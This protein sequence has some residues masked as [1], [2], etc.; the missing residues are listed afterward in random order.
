MSPEQTD[1]Q[2]LTSDLNA[3]V[4]A[5][6][7]TLPL[8]SSIDY[9]L[10]NKEDNLPTQ[11]I[12]NMISVLA[13]NTSIRAHSSAQEQI[14]ELETL[15][16]FSLS[17][18]VP[19]RREAE[20][21]VN[22]IKFSGQLTWL[23]EI[24]KKVH[25]PNVHNYHLQE[26]RSGDLI[27]LPHTEGII[28]WISLICNPEYWRGDPA[29][30]ALITSPEL[31]SSL[32]RL[33]LASSD[34]QL[35]EYATGFGGALI[36]PDKSALSSQQKR[37]MWN[38]LLMHDKIYESGSSDPS[39]RESVFRKIAENL[40]RDTAGIDLCGGKGDFLAFLSAVRRDVQLSLADIATQAVAHAAELGF[41]SRVIDLEEEVLAKKTK[42]I[43]LTFAAHLLSSKALE[44]VY[45]SLDRDGIFIFNIYPPGQNEV[46]FYSNL[47]RK[48]GFSQVQVEYAD[49]RIDPILIARK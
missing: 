8:I 35:P 6:Y 1:Y 16:T 32:T 44:S 31:P 17:D 3:K 48:I 18:E 5:Y 23:Q 34:T 38:Q 12:G 29:Y 36:I 30:Y 13:A 41:Q 43:T 9:F 22:L 26:H 28:K 33:V 42:C 20:I 45:A 14:E 39:R 46:N 27:I 15:T 7:D 24:I 19:G 2:K 25:S 49:N 40:P 47:I 37:D 11:S 21:A 4:R 10:A